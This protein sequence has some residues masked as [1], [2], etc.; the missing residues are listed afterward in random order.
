MNFKNFK[1]VKVIWK[2]AQTILGRNC[3]LK[4]IQKLELAKAHTIGYLIH[5]DK[6]KIA[7]CGH[8]FEKSEEGEFEEEFRDTHFILKSC[9]CEIIELKEIKR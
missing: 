7:I 4:E 5:E 3:S 1:L 9:V 6:E 2:D 8:Y